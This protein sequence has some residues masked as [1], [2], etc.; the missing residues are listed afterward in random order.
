MASRS[1]SD[2]SYPP[3]VPMFWHTG[4]AL[5]P[6]GLAISGVQVLK[7][8]CQRLASLV[9]RWLLERN[10]T[11]SRVSDRNRY[12]PHPLARR[13]RTTGRHLAKG[14]SC[15]LTP[16]LGAGFL[17]PPPLYLQ[18]ALPNAYLIAYTTQVSPAICVSFHPSHT[19]GGKGLRED[20]FPRSL[21]KAW[22]SFGSTRPI[23]P[24][25]ADPLI[26]QYGD[27]DHHHERR[28]TREIAYGTRDWNECS[29][30]LHVALG[31]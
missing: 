20:P 8:A 7:G 5:G 3:C 15:R 25:L 13:R 4:G 28:R 14:S 31:R 22:R 16:G 23:R 12:H 29:Q 11:T 6:L 18:T 1:V 2:R 24:P 10:E 9:R 17:T 21:R 30:S 27:S 26:Y 19:P